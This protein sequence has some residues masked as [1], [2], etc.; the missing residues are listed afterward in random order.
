LQSS[1]T[2]KT[3]KTISFRWSVNLQRHAGNPIAPGG[4]VRSAFVSMPEATTTPDFPIA[5]KFATL[6]VLSLPARPS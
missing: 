6:I 5:G 4:F 3:G 2:K 1:L